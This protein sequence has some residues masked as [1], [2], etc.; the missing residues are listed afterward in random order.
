MGGEK[1]KNSR[2]RMTIGKWQLVRKY[3][4]Q[5]QDGGIGRHTEPPRTTRTDGES[6]GKEV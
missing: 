3:L 4:I 2:G 5:N 1:E 6:N